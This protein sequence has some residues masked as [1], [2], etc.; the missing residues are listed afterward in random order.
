MLTVRRSASMSE[1]PASWRARIL[2]LGP[3]QLVAISVLLNLGL[4]GLASVELFDQ[5]VSVGAVL[6]AWLL[7]VALVG[8]LRD[9]SPLEAG[10][11]VGVATAVGMLVKLVVVA[12]IQ[13]WRT[14]HELALTALIVGPLPLGVLSGVAAGVPASAVIWVIRRIQ[15]VRARNRTG[16]A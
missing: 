5:G 8:L 7:F 15:G 12:C 2:R 16:P 9:D 13:W 10:V 1:V 14:E 4:G 11:V 3:W 6:P